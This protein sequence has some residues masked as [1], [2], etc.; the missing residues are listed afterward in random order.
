[1]MKAKWVMRLSVMSSLSW[2]RVP[3]AIV[4]AVGIAGLLAP[5]RTSDT[6]HKFKI[7]RRSSRRFLRLG[8]HALR[9]WLV[10]SD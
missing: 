6:L 9:R 8:A 7:L 10:V 1:V 5:T 2:S 3:V 4:F